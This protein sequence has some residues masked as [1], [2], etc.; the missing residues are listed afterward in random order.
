ML[1][2]LVATQG[3]Q[4]GLTPS[5]LS[6]LA[7][8]CGQAF[9]RPILRLRCGGGILAYCQCLYHICLFSIVTLYQH[10][11]FF[12][13]H[14]ICPRKIGMLNGGKEHVYPTL[15]LGNF[16]IHNSEFHTFFHTRFNY[17]PHLSFLN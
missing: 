1:L 4:T 7:L 12:H 15:I 5:H 6:F 16:G 11:V 10:D 9:P 8:H 2:R 17:F 3:P 13:H 14:H